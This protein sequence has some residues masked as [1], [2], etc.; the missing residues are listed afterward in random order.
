MKKRFPTNPKVALIRPYISRW[1]L[2]RWYSYFGSRQF[3]LGLLYIASYL[4]QKGF[5]VLLLD[6]EQ[7]GEKELLK[8]LYEYKPDV[9]GI[10][11]TTFSFSRGADL[12]KKIKKVLPDLSAF[13][14]GPHTSALPEESLLLIDQL[15]GVVI[16]EGEETFFEIVSNVPFENIDG[17]CFRDESGR[18][19]IN[20]Q[21]KVEVNLDKYSLNWNLLS[22]FPDSYY[23]TSQS[24]R[25]KS[26]SL[27][28]SRG[29]AYSC[30]FCAGNI[31]SGRKRRAHSPEYTVN[32]ITELYNRYGIK[33][34][35]FHDDHFTFDKK[36]IEKFCEL[37]KKLA[38]EVKW[39]C[40]SR[41]DLLNENILTLMKQSGCVQIGVG[42]EF[43]SQHMLD[44]IDKKIKIDTIHSK[45]NLI[46]KSGIDIKGYFIFDFPDQKL[47]DLWK[48]IKLILS[49]RFG[50]I[51]INYF[52]PLPGSDDFSR[53]P[54]PAL[55]WYKLNLRDPLG[56]AIKFTSVYYLLEI[57]L[58]SYIQL[59]AFI[60]KYFRR[61]TT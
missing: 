34:I 25:N 49:F 11:A 30:S 53:Y 35:Y 59:K 43:A 60:L 14:G 17:L 58:Y 21:R 37:L 33:E 20:R 3:S 2:Y 13:M 31:V 42:I 19:L 32:V 10:T 29:C 7:I 61:S 24:R 16:G 23:P 54:V 8:K 45:L 52:T 48:S 26:T 55:K 51:Q 9:L 47:K 46:N 4:N 1:Q 22:G 41:V 40:A 44:K 27:V 56:F 36:W 50:T 18:I 57:I 39:Y 6:G 28:I 38:P 5:D 12:I 15:D